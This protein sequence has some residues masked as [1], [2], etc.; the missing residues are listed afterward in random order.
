MSISILRL[1]FGQ[2]FGGQVG[3][4][5]GPDDEKARLFVGRYLKKSPISNQR[6]SVSTANGDT[7]VTISSCQ[8]G[9]VTATRSFTILEFLAELQCLLPSRWEQTTRFFGV[10]S[11]RSRGD[12]KEKKD[13]TLATTDHL[14]DFGPAPFRHCLS[15]VAPCAAGAKEEAACMARTFEIDPLICS[16]C[17]SLLKIKAF[18]IRL[19]P[20]CAGCYVGQ[21]DPREAFRIAEHLGANAGPGPPLPCSVPD[22]A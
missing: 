3:K 17:G 11:S 6:L 2:C 18:I 19:R 14:P 9:I 7:T 10:Y 13:E 5:I 16:K 12:E 20:C 22:A 15:A 4:P 21:A 8:N 1:P